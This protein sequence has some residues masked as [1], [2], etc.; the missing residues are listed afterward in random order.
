MLIHRLSLSSFPHTCT[1]ISSTV[2]IANEAEKYKELLVPDEGAEYDQL[3]EINL[4][5]VSQYNSVITIAH[6]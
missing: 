2:A 1:L 3:V 5:E 6:C 4:D